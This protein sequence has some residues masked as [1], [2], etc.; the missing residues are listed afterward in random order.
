MKFFAPIDITFFARELLSAAK[1]ILLKIVN[2]KI[3]DISVNEIV[4]LIVLIMTSI[5]MGISSESSLDAAHQAFWFVIILFFLQLM[6][7]PLNMVMGYYIILQ[8][9]SEEFKARFLDIA[10]E[11]VLMIIFAKIGLA[12]SS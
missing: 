9:I 11:Y 7:N 6:F 5:L 12:I 1:D 2:E 8:T 3:Y 10:L 4:A